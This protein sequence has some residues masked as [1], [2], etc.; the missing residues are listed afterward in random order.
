MT[1]IG[2]SVPNRLILVLNGT[3]TLLQVVLGQGGEIH[4]AKSI[5]VVAQSMRFLPEILEDCFQV[6]GFKPWQLGG[7]ACVRGP[8]MFTGIR[9][10]LSIGLG[11]SKGS[12]IPMAGIDYLPLLATQ[13][14]RQINTQGEVW[15]CTYARKNVCYLQGFTCPG[16]RALS[17][18]LALSFEE[19]L[20]LFSGRK[21]RIFLVGSGIRGDQAWWLENLP[22]AGVLDK[23]WDHPSCQLLLGKSLEADYSHEPVRPLYVRASDAEEHLRDVADQRGISYKQARD[24]IPD[25]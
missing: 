19:T 15:V 9:V 14:S 13:A 17:P 12:N 3:E 24:S 4:Y 18:P 20:D 5:R 16:V 6:T 23:I 2:S 21:E 10:V 7:L 11:L 25:Y 1:C 22:G 8:G